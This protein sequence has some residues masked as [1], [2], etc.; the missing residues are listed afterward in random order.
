MEPV[1][2]FGPPSAENCTAALPLSYT[3]K[4]GADGRI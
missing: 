2:G 4:N 3:G 1:E